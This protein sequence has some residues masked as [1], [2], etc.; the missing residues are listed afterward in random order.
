MCYIGG[1]VRVLNVPKDKPLVGYRAWD[2]GLRS[3]Y[4]EFFWEGIGKETQ[5]INEPTTRNES[6]LYA[7]KSE[8]AYNK[9]MGHKYGASTTNKLLGYNPP[10]HGMVE[11][12]GK[13]VEHRGGYRASHARITKIVKGK[14]KA[15]R[16]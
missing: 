9:E 1:R 14:M 6:G 5:P 11:M 2:E 16:K 12:W 7:F 10:I 3:L 8:E 15:K 13:V 4:A